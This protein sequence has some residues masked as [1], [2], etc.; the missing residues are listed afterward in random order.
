MSGFGVVEM[1]RGNLNWWILPQTPYILPFDLLKFSSL[2]T[3]VLSSHLKDPWNSNLVFPYEQFS[4][5]QS[6]NLVHCK[7]PVDASSDQKSQW[8]KRTRSC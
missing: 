1:K 3:W 2:G 4:S 6:V 5:Y 7:V 8:E